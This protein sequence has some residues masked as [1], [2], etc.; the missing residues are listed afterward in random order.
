[1]RGNHDQRFVDLIWNDNEAVRAKFLEHGGIHTIQSYCG[2]ESN[3]TKELL[4]QGIRWIRD[5]FEH[6]IQ[7]LNSLPLYYEDS[8]HIYVHAGI[9]P[10]YPDW[11]K[12]P[13]HDFMYIKDA[14]FRARFQLERKI[15]FGHT[16]TMDIHGCPDVWFDVDKIGIDGGCAYG[17]QLNGLIFQDGNYTV[18]RINV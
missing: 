13:D 3:E 17:M 16:K 2:T 4:N 9:N 11:R 8:D 5:R 1:M 18:E 14:F 15:I 6:H 7:F 10:D 12:Q